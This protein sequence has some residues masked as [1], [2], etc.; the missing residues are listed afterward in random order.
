MILHYLPCSFFFFFLSKILLCVTAEWLPGNKDVTSSTLSYE[1]YK[2][3]FLFLTDA[4]ILVFILQLFRGRITVKRDGK[5]TLLPP[6]FFPLPINL[7]ET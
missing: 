7:L 4:V 2:S 6:F 5:H 3:P 1:P